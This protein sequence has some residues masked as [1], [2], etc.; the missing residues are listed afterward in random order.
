M[1]TKVFFSLSIALLLVF[2]IASVIALPPVPPV[3][4][5]TP[6]DEDECTAT[7]DGIEICDSIDNDCDGTFDEDVCTETPE[8][9]GD[10]SGSSSSGGGSSGGGGGG[11]GGGSSGS[12]I[13]FPSSSDSNDGSSNSQTDSQDMQTDSGT[14]TSS[15]EENENDVSGS[16]SS[17]QEEN[18]SSSG[19]SKILSIQEFISSNY[20]GLITGSAILLFLSLIAIFIFIKVHHHA[21]TLN[22]YNSS[23][24]QVSQREMMA[25]KYIQQMRANNYSENDIRTA[26]KK[27]GWNDEQINKLT[28]K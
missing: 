21:T 3:E 25:S 9:T 13:Y 4:P 7:N 2:S 8:D 23:S 11:S 16:A 26:M 1:Y 5:G 17:S 27:S 24:S 15:T 14:E 20:K 19:A 12:I 18:L 6:P 28:K 10:D 22:P